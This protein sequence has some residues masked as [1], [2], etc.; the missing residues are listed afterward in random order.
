MNSHN[1][2]KH[3]A[4]YIGIAAAAVASCTPTPLQ[5]EANFQA[6]F[7]KPATLKEDDILL[8]WTADDQVSLFNKITYNQPYGFTGKKGNNAVGFQKV[9][10]EEFITGN[11]ISHVVSVYPYQENTKVDESEVISLTLPAE[12]SYTE[13]TFALDANTMVSVS[14]GNVLQYK[15]VGGYFVLN[16]YGEGATV[17]SI[18][19]K[20][21]NGE[22]LA[23]KASV[24]MPLDGVPSAV[25]AD[26]AT[27]EIT[28]VFANPVQL[29]ATAENA[30]PFWFVVPPV[31]FEKGFTISV[32]GENG[33][34]LKS[35][36]ETLTLERNNLSKVPAIEI[37]P[38]DFITN[39]PFEDSLFKDYC[40]RYYDANR[41]GEISVLDEAKGV[42]TI[43]VQS[44]TFYAYRGIT[45]LRG[46]EY[47]CNLTNLD[48]SGQPLTSLDVSKNTA[49]KKLY[50]Q[51]D[52]LTS[53]D[54]SNNVD[55]EELVC[56]Q[57]SL[58]SLDVSKNTALKFIYCDY[59]QLT[60]LDLSGKTALE[61]VQ[62]SCNQ[63][64]S[65]DIS[66]CKALN[67]LSCDQNQLTSL[68]LS[69]CPGLTRL[70]CYD[71]Q[72]VNLNI[73]GCTALRVIYCYN[74]QLVNLNVNENKALERL[75][76]EDNQ[77]V[78]LELSACT[79]LSYLKCQN[80]R[81][82]NIDLSGK[83]SL[84]EVYCYDNLLTSLDVSDCWPMSTLW[85]YNNP[86]LS[87]IWLRSRQWI[88]EFK[89]DEN[90]A[91]IKYKP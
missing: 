15:N 49:L 79:K 1:K 19:L 16:L 6:S 20:G 31:T 58:S 84:D 42:T 14:S 36:E 7:E 43:L 63:L 30:T 81:L 67:Y 88:P 86:N 62:C 85:C 69:G 33:V 51:S 46:I 66:G 83:E 40:V 90:I 34:F 21:N 53:L 8:R 38:D 82:T 41:D 3:I 57:N 52:R 27:S 48:C 59:N 37:R 76:C 61:E 91:T 71:N 87:E 72:L 50:C 47:F 2:M 56:S 78:S 80:N 32:T 89:Y 13:N 22:K 5:D 10:T 74:N 77:L 18:T 44:N 55:L 28:L 17:S 39:V 29:G 26:D 23:G 68:D 54:L 45:S 9:D 70:F 75:F 24:T 25:M 12:Q 35:T 65:L 64:T 73:S 60:S 11:P 4:L